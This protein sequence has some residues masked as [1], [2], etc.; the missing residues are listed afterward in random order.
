MRLSSRA[1]R[2]AAHDLNDNTTQI[3]AAKKSSRDRHSP[4]SM[5]KRVAGR[6]S[7]SSRQSRKS[8]LFLEITLFF[9]AHSGLKSGCSKLNNPNKSPSAGLFPGTYGLAAFAVG[10]GRLS[11]LRVVIAGSFQFRSMNLIS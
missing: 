3:S 5:Q 9:A 7:R 10:S 1:T 8:Y 11:R 2:R 6:S 4:H